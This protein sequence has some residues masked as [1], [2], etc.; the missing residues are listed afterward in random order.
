MG[1]SELFEDVLMSGFCYVL[2]RMCPNKAVYGLSAVWRKRSWLFCSISF[3]LL[4]KQSLTANRK[5]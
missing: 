2:S 5:N 1:L 4:F 3:N